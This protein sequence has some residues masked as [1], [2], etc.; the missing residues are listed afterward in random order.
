M[1]AAIGAC[2]EARQDWGLGMSPRSAC[3]Q[4]HKDFMDKDTAVEDTAVGDTAV[5]A[6][7]PHQGR[8]PHFVS[9]PCSLQH[10]N[11]CSC[12]SHTTGLW[13]PASGKSGALHVVHLQPPAEQHMPA[14]L[15]CGI[16]DLG[17]GLPVVL[18]L[19]HTGVGGS[20]LL[21]NGALPSLH[22]SPAVEATICALKVRGCRR[23][24]IQ[25]LLN[26]LL[27]HHSC[28]LARNFLLQTL[29]QAL[30][31]DVSCAGRHHQSAQ[32]GACGLHLW[33]SHCSLSQDTLAS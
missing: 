3:C 24:S 8:A 15:T 9:A 25:A 31:S 21:G 28:A 10:N 22:G 14:S 23:P 13:H 5:K 19:V 1:C 33:L 7:L 17:K 4:S 16:L 27:A 11:A 6:Q 12:L 32:V 2:T 30:H 26:S 18:H 29:L 20:L